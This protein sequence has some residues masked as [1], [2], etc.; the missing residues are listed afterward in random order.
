MHDDLSA[1]G[2]STPWDKVFVFCQILKWNLGAHGKHKA[3]PPVYVGKTME[4]NP[5]QINEIK[6]RNQQCAS[7]SFTKPKN[8]NSRSSQHMAAIQLVYQIKSPPF[9]VDCST[10]HQMHFLIKILFWMQLISQNLNCIRLFPASRKY[11]AR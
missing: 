3:H 1:H 2:F 8:C 7:I 6:L 9:D 5:N 4:N 10:K 11:T